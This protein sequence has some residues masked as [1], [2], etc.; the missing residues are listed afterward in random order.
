[1]PKVGELATGDKKLTI[2]GYGQAMSGKTRFLSSLHKVFTGRIYII[3]YDIEDNLMPLMMDPSMKEVEYD[4]YD[5]DKGYDNLVKKIVEL[6]RNCPYDIIVFE[7]LNR[8]YKNTMEQ[9]LRLASRTELDGARIQDWGLANK[10]VYDRLKEILSLDGPRCIYVTTH[11]H[12]EKDE[13]TGRLIGQILIPSKQ[14]PDE[15]PPMFNINM[16]FYTIQAVGKEPEYW[17]QCKGDGTWGAGDKTGTLAFKEEPDFVKMMSK[18]GRNFLNTKKPAATSDVAIAA[19]KVE[20]T[21]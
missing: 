19:V 11:Q 5:H 14:L 12:L 1:M 7:N 20:E 17:V 6:K 4:Q 2:L 16:R 13:T 15:I 10:R 9:V 21:K 3:N 8:F 18:M